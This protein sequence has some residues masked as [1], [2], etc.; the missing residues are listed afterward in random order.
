M[1]HP[2]GEPAERMEQAFRLD[3]ERASGSSPQE[4]EEEFLARH[5]ALRDLLEPML[6]GSDAD[7]ET[8][9]AA[10]A[11][12]APRKVGDYELLEEE[13][14]AAWRSSTKRATSRAIGTSR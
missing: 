6:A 7:E 11:E 2:S 3:L 4:S 13:D 14:A 5:E 9:S 8:G 10:S 12:R 1:T